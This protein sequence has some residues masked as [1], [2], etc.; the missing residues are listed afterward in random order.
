[1]AGYIGSK[2]SVVS[3]GAERKKTFTITGATTSLTGLNYTVGKVHVFQ[4][5]VR[6]VDGTDYTATN[7]TTITLTVAAQSGDNVVVISQ[8]SYQVADAVLTSGD[9][10]TGD[11]SLGDNNKVIF[12]AGSDLQIYH[13]GSHSVIKDAG[14]GNLKYQAASRHQFEN[15]DGSKMYMQLVG[16]IVGQEYVQ[17][18]YN[19]ATKLATTSTGIDVTGTVTADGLTLGANNANSPQILFENSDGVTGDAAL[20]TYDD[21]SGTMLVMGSNF[22]IN[23]SGSETRF[24][25]SEESS[26]VMLNRN[27]D[28]NLLTGGTGAT[29]TTRLKIDSSGNV[30]ISTSSPN[31]NLHVSGGAGDVAFGITNAATGTAS[32]DGFSITVENPTP[33]VAIRQR[34]NNNMKFLTNN[35]ERMRIDNSGRVTMPYQP[36]FRAGRNGNY[37]AGINNDIVFNLT[38]GTQLF[39]TG[40]HYSTTT[41]LFTAPVTGS[42]IFHVVVVWGPSMPEGEDMADSFRL[43]HNG[44]KFHYSERRAEYVNGSTGNGGY[45]VDHATCLTHMDANDTMGVRSQESQTVHGNA[46]YTTFT[47]HLLG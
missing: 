37:I 39:N 36:S 14:T 21:S 35:T 46:Q 47:G 23:S 3:S 38:S 6:L 29:A 32:S 7:G 20:S 25:T 30:G 28:L 13:D 34:E 33:D 40:S 4:N 41:G 18:R 17:L 15:A 5:G 27:G 19:N 43:V 11:L 26:A 12:G 10:M 42:Y 45:Y 1:M 24:N 2:A 8:A 22:Y 16:D 9:S 31:R 44:N